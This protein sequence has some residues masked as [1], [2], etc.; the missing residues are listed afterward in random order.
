MYGSLSLSLRVVNYPFYIAR[1][2]SLSASG[3]RSS[4]AVKVA[5]AAVALS[6]AV[7]LAAIAVVG[8]FKQEIRAKVV[9]FN[10][11]LSIYAVPTEE[12]GNTLTLTPT[13]RNLLLKEPYVESI[14]L[15]VTVPAVLKTESDFKGIY[16]KGIGEGA[17]T[18]FLSTNLIEGKVPDFTAPG[19]DSLMVVSRKTADEL[20]LHIGDKVPAY[21]FSDDLRVRPLRVAAIT[22]SHFEGYDNIYIYGSLALAQ[23]LA[24]LSPSQGT[25]LRVTTTDFNL[26]DQY[27]AALGNKLVK[28]YAEAD[29][30]TPL[31]V[32]NAMVQGAAYFN[33]LSLLD[34][35]VLVI[36][37][38]MTVVACVTLIS[39]LLIL[40][41]DKV[42]TIGV[43]RALGAS[44]KAVRRVFVWLACKVAIIGLIAGNGLMLLVLW[45]QQRTHFFHLDPDSYYIDFVP[46]AI[47]WQGVLTLNAAVLL[48]VWLSLLLPAHF[49]SR[50]SPAS[51]LRFE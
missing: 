3:R 25:A 16:L 35:N 38:L 4:P 40:I 28:A 17:D 9:G 26:V 22:D 32:E 30:F 33:W 11:H 50:V 41:L 49:I 39:G 7:M 48:I 8:G 42:R 14:A 1:R 27:S 13:L 46:V 5:V 19:A 24:A 6:I 34:T 45:L 36:L 2:L 37:I 10:S 47:T 29:I 21:F 31:R 23:Q 51:T 43:L 18:A 44:E 20:G 15:E 12:A